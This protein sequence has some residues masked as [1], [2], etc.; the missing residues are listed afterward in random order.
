MNVNTFSF[1]NDKLYFCLHI[2]ESASYFFG[3][4]LKTFG[5]IAPCYRGPVASLDCIFPTFSINPLKLR[6]ANLKLQPHSKLQQ[7]PHLKLQQQPHLKLQ[8]QQHFLL[9]QQIMSNP[10]IQQ[11]FQLKKQNV[12][13]F[14]QVRPQRQP[15]QLQKETL[16]FIF[17]MTQNF[18]K[19]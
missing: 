6:P 9:H 13:I 4:F 3:I 19:N 18:I 11:H 7:Q 5:D 14:Q 15:Y 17:L 16:K 10:Q 1:L 8:Q 2:A 12:H